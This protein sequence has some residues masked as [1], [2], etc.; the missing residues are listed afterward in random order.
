ML[1]CMNILRLNGV[2]HYQRFGGIWG[3]G[4]NKLRMYR[5]FKD[6]LYVEHYVTDVWSKPECSA[7]AKFRCGVAPLN[8]EPGLYSTHTN[9]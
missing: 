5:T 9:L 1:F 4:V 3:E 7:M 8:I 6:E 2:M